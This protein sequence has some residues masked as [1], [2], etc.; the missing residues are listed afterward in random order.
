MT[1]CVRKKPL[2][3][4]SVSP[5]KDPP[6]SRIKKTSA[7]PSA[8]FIPERGG[9]KYREIR[10]IQEGSFAVVFEVKSPGGTQS[11]LKVAKPEK[12]KLTLAEARTLEAAQ[13]IPHVIGLRDHF[14]LQSSKEYA[15]L[16]DLL[17]CPDVHARYIADDSRAKL[18]V[19]EIIDMGKQGLEALSPLHERGIVHFDIKPENLAYHEGRLIIFD[20]GG[21]KKSDAM[22]PG[23]HYGGTTFYLSPEILRGEDP[24][25]ATDIW[26]LA[27]TLTE[28]YIGAPLFRGSEPTRSAQKVIDVLHQISKIMGVSISNTQWLARTYAPELPLP[29]KM[30]QFL[31]QYPNASSLPPPSTMIQ[32]RMD[33]I[34]T[35]MEGYPKGF[36]PWKALIHE[37]AATKNDGMFA[38]RILTAFLDPMFRVNDRISAEDA[39]G[40]IPRYEERLKLAKRLE[41]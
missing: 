40:L 35:L 18:S 6:P 3:P 7:R 8:I 16:M 22:I 14:K 11:A 4:V 12:S 30:K 9:K 41:H 32:Q 39:L 15:I 34:D 24:S 1:T 19:A 38:A 29:P 5:P 26:S 33:Q 31:E 10:R 20:L 23:E 21:S 25:A 36:P 37:V 13:G 2:P 17:P 28:L 27:V